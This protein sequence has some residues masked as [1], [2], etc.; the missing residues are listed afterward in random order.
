MRLDEALK[1]LKENDYVVISEA[2]EKDREKL[3]KD[4]RNKIVPEMMEIIFKRS[5]GE[6]EFKYKIMECYE[7]ISKIMENDNLNLSQKAELILDSY[8]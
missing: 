1:I 7:P 3:A 5:F 6:D 8:M 2:T 4:V